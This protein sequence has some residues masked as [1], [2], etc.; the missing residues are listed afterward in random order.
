MYIYIYIP[1]ILIYIYI[2]YIYEYD[3]I[4]ILTINHAICSPFDRRVVI[5]IRVSSASDVF[6]CQ[7]TNREH[8]PMSVMMSSIASTLNC[9]VM[10][11]FC[12]E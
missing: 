5:F 9:C 10:T 2:Y 11:V 6:T 12:G 1:Y 4:Y 3:N 8:T 7:R